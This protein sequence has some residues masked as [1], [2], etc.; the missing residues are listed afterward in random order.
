MTAVGVMLGFGVIFLV[1]EFFQIYMNKLSYLQDF[2]NVFDFARGALIIVYCIRKLGE[3]EE[4]QDVDHSKINDYLL[5]T[6]TILSWF[7]G[8]SYLR[9]FKQT[10]S[11]IRL[12][13]EV[14]KDMKAFSIVLLFALSGFTLTY[15]S[16]SGNHYFFGNIYRVSRFRWFL[17]PYIPLDAR[18]LQ[19]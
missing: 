16:L 11:L 3:G 10:R 1:I 6:L 9:L 5:A 7:R 4:I 12:I 13:I 19:L 8:I 2:W 17:I 14:I 18:R 15:Y